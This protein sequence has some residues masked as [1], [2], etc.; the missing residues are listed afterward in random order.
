[1]RKPLCSCIAAVASRLNKAPFLYRL[2]TIQHLSVYAR[3]R[4]TRN[5]DMYPYA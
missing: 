4:L 1:M 3:L 2:S 5:L